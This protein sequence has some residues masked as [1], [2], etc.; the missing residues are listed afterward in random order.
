MVLGFE[1]L[2]L[3]PQ[4]IETVKKM[5]FE[6]PTPIQQAAIP[7]LL[8]GRN[9]VGQAQ[10]GTG[11]TAAFALPL[12]QGLKPGKNG[13]QAL[14][15]TPT[16]EL[17]IQ[18]A[19]ATTRM[20]EDSLARVLA[21]YGGQSYYV[22]TKQLKRGVDVVVGTPGRLLDL[23]R[24]EVLDLS[25]V[26]YLVLDEADEMLEMGFI[27]DVETIFSSMP[28]ERQI[29]LFSATLPEAI[30]KLAQRYVSDPEKISINPTRITVSETEQ[31]FCQVREGNKLTALTRM[32]EMEEVK[33]ALIFT[34]TKVRA[35]E[36]SDELAE[37]GY[38]VESLH[39]DL[40]QARREQVLNRFR[41]HTI[42]ILVATDVA[43]RGLDIENVSHVINYDASNDAEDYVHRIGRTGR[44]GRKGIA[45]SLVTPRELHWLHQ[46][47]AFTRSKIVEVQAPTREALMARRDE[48]FLERLA[49]QQLA[50]GKMSIER[51]L[52]N[53]LLESGLDL[54]DIATAAIHM[55]RAGESN[56]AGGDINEPVRAPKR[57]MPAAILAKDSKKPARKGNRENR[58]HKGDAEAMPVWNKREKAVSPR[59]LESGMVRLRMNLGNTHGIRPG[60]VVGAIAGE[61]GIPGRAIGEIDIRK[62][63]T[64]VDVAAKH[65]RKILRGSIGQYM[66]SGKP[67]L[68]TQVN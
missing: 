60:D 48:L 66:I 3:L 65:V 51:N 47:E 5:G 62:D 11:K 28:A 16:R 9:V 34:R 21:V 30:R 32:L 4:F 6:S 56:I 36:L 33:S 50:K 54:M 10:T 2:G 59:P 68:L 23:I 12:L 13:V 29:A 61:V 55:A 8:A 17:A 27:D 35:Q 22:Q 18:V 1:N 7:A 42:N 63:Y 20:A 67:V 46:V 41:Q 37:R 19:E 39:G 14:I 31:R 38:P 25:Q 49:E 58:E 45:I 15:L 26:R 43:A 57:E 44:A 52:V 53:Q 40:N 64:L 24:Q